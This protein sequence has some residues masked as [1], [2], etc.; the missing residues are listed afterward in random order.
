MIDALLALLNGRNDRPIERVRT[1]NHPGSKRPQS[2][3]KAR[4]RNKAA[5]KARRANR[6]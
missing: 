6:R 1:T 4:A 5:R 2:V 3:A